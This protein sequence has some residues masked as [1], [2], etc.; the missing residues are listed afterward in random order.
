M[1]GSETVFVRVKV[2]RDEDQPSYPE[3]TMAQGWAEVKES[4]ATLEEGQD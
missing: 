4:L 3:R 1:S 2:F